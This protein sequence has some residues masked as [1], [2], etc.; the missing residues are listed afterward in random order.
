MKMSSDR[1]KDDTHH[2]DKSAKINSAQKNKV[3][4]KEK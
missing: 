2:S 1:I 3:P 4:D